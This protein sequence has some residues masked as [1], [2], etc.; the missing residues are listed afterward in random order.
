M[1]KFFSFARRIDNYILSLFGIGPTS[2][3][4]YRLPTAGTKPQMR[5]AFVRDYFASQPSMLK[6]TLLRVYVY[7]RHYSFVIA[8][9]IIGFVVKPLKKVG[10]NE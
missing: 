2:T 7:S 6:V 10:V 5:E 3:Y 4:N 9:K 1:N 8:R